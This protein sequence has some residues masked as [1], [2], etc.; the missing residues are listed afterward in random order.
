MK[1]DLKRLFLLNNLLTSLLPIICVGLLSLAVVKSHLG[2]EHD[3]S[4]ALLA[5]SLASQITTYLHEPEST[6]NLVTRHLLTQ[7]HSSADRS[8]MLDLLAASYEY[9]NALYLLDQR[10]I[11]QQAGF[12]EQ[13]EQA[14]SDYLGMDFSSVEACRQAL[15]DQRLH[16]VPSVSMSSGAPTM[17]FCGPLNGGTLLA[18][19]K[20]TDLG[21]IIN[22]ASSGGV[23]TAFIVDRTGQLI[24]HPDQGIMQQKENVSN[25][26]LVRSALEGA[27]RTGDFT[28]HG[29]EYRG[30]VV[31]L[32]GLKWVL[33]VAQ[34]MDH[35]M[36]PIRAMQRIL[37]SGLGATLVM[38]LLLGMLG[39]RQLRR[40][41]DQL[42]ENARRVIREE[43]DAVQPISSMCVE[44]AI[45]SET[46]LRM[47]QAVR[48]RE[49]MLNEQT[50]E[51]MATEEQLREL[52][53]FLE[54]KVVER[55]AQ[56]ESANWEL[57][58][59]ND[60]LQQRENSLAGAN[61]QL[62]TFAY[63]IS[64]DLRAPLR[65]AR[66]FAGIL[67]EDHGPGMTGAAQ[68]LARRIVVSCDRMDSLIEG[69]LQ[70]S[71]VTRQDIT[72]V[73]VATELMVRDI[74]TDM[75]LDLQ[76]RTVEVVIGNLSDCQ[77][78]PL[79][80]RQ[81]WANLIGNAVKYTRKRPDARIEVSCLQNGGETV[82]SIRD[83]GVGF[84]MSRIEKLFGVFQRYHSAAEF[85]GTGVGLAIVA[86]IIQRHGGRIWAEAKPDVGATFSF[87]LSG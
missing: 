34:D 36:A 39:S 76:G 14:K 27:Q 79:L 75:Q 44:V 3:R 8:K 49:E 66:S 56:L 26:S 72:K 2:K 18:E 33:V 38:A 12:K 9:F 23:F 63:S 15:Q 4:N 84:D 37:L 55:T 85:E 51:L 7:Q 82:Y 83:N 19:L 1:Y 32:P 59:L 35:V 87:T 61:Q 57:S 69:V 5:Q 29:V 6:F 53:Q 50:E 42:A 10:G 13:A 31:P 73:P 58:A 65:H 21:R 60:D 17:S 80:L 74:F 28:F 16:W 64:H 62:E 67:L 43:Y 68:D 25:L 22:E 20:L 45:L 81:V 78:D 40:P 71:R 47:V 70:F 54:E 86:N 48:S 77:A 52:N 11:V 30:T 41:F 24:V 46:L